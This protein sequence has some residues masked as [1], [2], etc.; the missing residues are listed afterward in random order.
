MEEDVQWAT[1]LV[2]KK[3][4]LEAK[5]HV[6]G[7]SRK[8]GLGTMDMQML[9][10]QKCEEAKDQGVTSMAVRKTSSDLRREIIDLGGIQNLLELH[11]KRKCRKKK[12][13][14]PTAQEPEGQNITG[15]VEVSQFLQ[16]AAQGKIKV[17]EKFLED[18]GN[19]SSY[20]EFKRTALHRAS[21]EGHTA[22]VQ[23]LLD[24]GVDVNFKDRLDSGAL[25]WACRGGSLEVLKV[26]QNSGANLNVQD[27]LMSTPLHV[28]T[29]TGHYDIVEHLICSGIK[30]NSKDREGDTALHDAIRLSRYRIVRLLLLHGA[31]M[32]VKN[33]E[34]KT[35]SDLVMQ[36]QFDTKDVLERQAELSS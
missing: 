34:G 4:E 18:G 11:E 15:P 3:E 30:I 24:K 9:E 20:D 7:R 21:F 25:H 33:A 5:N 6:K 14:P 2:D 1:H 23:K 36:W 12:V 17:I 32:K 8:I 10:D 27:K 28:A 26:L 13:A 35:P 31:D 29:R 16:A 19:P 22:I